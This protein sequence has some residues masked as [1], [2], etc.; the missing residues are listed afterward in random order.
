MKCWRTF[1]SLAGIKPLENGISPVKSAKLCD[2]LALPEARILYFFRIG[3]DI[4]KQML[5]T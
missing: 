1:I 3:N 5:A 2:G 4:E